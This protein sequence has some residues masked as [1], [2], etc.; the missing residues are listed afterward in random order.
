MLLGQLPGDTSPANLFAVLPS[1]ETLLSRFLDR[2]GP[3]RLQRYVAPAAPQ[4]DAPA[5][6]AIP[7]LSA[8]VPPAPSR[9]ARFPRAGR[10]NDRR[11]V[12]KGFDPV[13]A[14]PGALTGYDRAIA[15]GETLANPLGLGFGFSNPGFIGLG[16]LAMRELSQVTRADAIHRINE[17]RRRGLINDANR[18][19]SGGAPTGRAGGVGKPGVGGG[20]SSSNRGPGAKG[21][22]FKS[23]GGPR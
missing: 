14:G 19:V 1:Y 11:A 23:F 12:G 7:P 21:D 22:G 13:G 2:F 16:G 17:A 15:L 18:R 3:Y 5:P 9:P 6:A 20:F 4:F 8:V 10:G